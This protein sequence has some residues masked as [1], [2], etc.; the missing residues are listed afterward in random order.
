ME[1]QNLLDNINIV[2]KR[3]QYI[4]SLIKPILNIYT[5][6]LA[7]P[8]LIERWN[9]Y[10]NDWLYQILSPFYTINL[11]HYDHFAPQQLS[12]LK[13][14][15]M[16]SEF[17]QIDKIK[18][19]YFVFDF[20]H[21]VIE[22]FSKDINAIYI[23]FN[24]TENDPFFEF[25]LKPFVVNSL[26]NI[27]TYTTQLLN[28]DYEI[29]DQEFIIQN[30]YMKSGIIDNKIKY[31]VIKFQGIIF[32]YDDNW[33]QTNNIMKYNKYTYLFNI[34]LQ[35]SNF[36]IE[37]FHAETIKFKHII[38][39]IDSIKK[40]LDKSSFRNPIRNRTIADADDEYKFD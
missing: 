19:P 1:I 13:S 33:I 29:I 14:G 40:E 22:D 35:A 31:K 10:I 7:Y 24:D 27:I 23:P 21:V 16:I 18:K 17:L 20:S 11:Q 38:D 15:Q 34:I 25:G 39:K 12:K 36:Y 4:N 5:T 28:G 6:G 3:K 8:G 26:G 37:D 30:K 9:K 2:Y 32:A